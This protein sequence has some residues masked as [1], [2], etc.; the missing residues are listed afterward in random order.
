MQPKVRGRY[1]SVPIEERLA[2][3]T[4]KTD[5]CW[6]WIGCINSTGYG[7]VSYKG[8][9]CRA[10]RV[11]YELENGPIPE[12]LEIDHLCE[13]RACV[14]PQH[15]E[16]VTGLVNS[17]RGNLKRRNLMCRR[18]LH[19]LDGENLY[20]SPSLRDGPTRRCR[21]CK[22]SRAKVDYKRHTLQAEQEEKP[23]NYTDYD[24]TGIDPNDTEVL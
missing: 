12:G 9:T 16:A 3:K 20:F 17:R 18:G 22:V 7:T 1:R 13:V 8:K 19:K 24:D 23:E 21:A 2:S 4:F 11:Y 14:N 10:H 15:L 6:L 5:T